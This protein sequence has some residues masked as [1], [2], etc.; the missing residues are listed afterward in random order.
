MADSKTDIQ[1]VLQLVINIYPYSTLSQGPFFH[2]SGRSTLFIAGASTCF[3]TPPFSYTKI[4]VRISPVGVIQIETYCLK[5]LEKLT[6]GEKD[7][8]GFCD[9]N[10]TLIFKSKFSKEDF[11]EI[12]Y[13]IV[14]QRKEGHIF[15][16]HVPKR[17][18][19]FKKI[20]F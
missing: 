11:L 6:E 7:I 19:V 10:E 15:L 5:S 12:N 20:D 4:S 8:L 17:P 13:E 16:Y 3:I 2:K 14:V 1:L 9:S 18:K